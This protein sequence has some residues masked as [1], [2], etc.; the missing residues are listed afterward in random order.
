M[1]DIYDIKKRA[2]ELSAKWKTES[3]P[4]EEVGDLIRDL[5]DYANQTEINGSSLGIRKT[6]ATVSAM[7]ADSN[8]VD[9]KDGT[10]L[11]RGML[12]NIYNQDDASA[13]DNGKVFSWQNP[14]WQLRTKLD[15]GYATTEQ[16]DAIKTEQ[17]EK[18]SELLIKTSGILNLVSK[19]AVSNNA[20][21]LFRNTE[22]PIRLHETIFF[23]KANN[24]DIV[25]K[26]L[27]AILKSATGDEI[28]STIESLSK[29][30]QPFAEKSEGVV[31]EKVYFSTGILDEGIT[32]SIDIAYNEGATMVQYQELIVQETGN[33]EKKVLSQAATTKN[34]STKKELFEAVA[35]DYS[36]IDGEYVTT[37][38]NITSI[39]GESY[40]RTD[41][42]KIEGLK[43]IKTLVGTEVAK[44]G[45][46]FFDKEKKFISAIDFSNQPYMSIIAVDVPE[47]SVYVVISCLKSNKDFFALYS[48]G[49][50]SIVL[51]KL[52]A[53]NNQFE[54]MQKYNLKLVDGFINS[55]HGGVLEATSYKRTDFVRIDAKNI[56]V[57]ITFS[58]ANVGFAFYD[59]FKRYISGFD[60]TSHSIGDIIDVEVPDEAAYFRTCAIN[61]A[62]SQIGVYIP[63]FV[64]KLDY[65]NP[66]FYREGTLCRVFKNILCI[67]DSL[68]QGSLDYKVD[69]VIK[70]FISEEYSYPG[71]LAALTGRK[72]TNKGDAGETTKT[73]WELHQSDEDFGGCDAC[74]IGLGRNDY[75]AS[76][77]TTSEERHEYMGKIIDKVRLENPQI[78]IFIATLLNYYRGEGA[79]AVNKDMRDIAV[80]K[81]C[82]LLD[83]SKYGK[84]VSNV[85]NKSH[86]TAVGYA[87]LAEYYYRYISYIMDS[88][89]DKF[90]NIQYV[91]SDKVW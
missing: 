60:G 36:I 56:K 66:C 61:S 51:N 47:L 40:F 80:E 88:E 57:V 3:I 15:A 53:L 76:K 43:R 52:N 5:A 72:T 28:V 22:N 13:P 48:I 30:W 75:E 46:A 16:V 49:T 32:A 68:T 83:I 54:N 71:Q 84:L 86:C 78:P 39:S 27:V 77:A 12:V 50:T 90:T 59:K 8:P 79:D 58:V 37:K 24:D 89:P 81:D 14:G 41:Y 44:V 7:E 38:G 45:L 74:I 21:Y 18:F 20:T 31:I 73:W 19:P 9:D 91:G 67:G 82:F 25:G 4:P 69:G 11:R 42:T 70:E 2:D 17:D 85:D 34:F 10:P 6:Y 23:A 65:F 64:N 26:Q 29:Q 1:A 63:N 87:K 62:V 33:N 35:L 55:S